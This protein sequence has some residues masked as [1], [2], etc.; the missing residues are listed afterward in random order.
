MLRGEIF[1]RA[2]SP[3]PSGGTGDERGSLGETA[4]PKSAFA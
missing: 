4:L 1:G 3:G 2:V